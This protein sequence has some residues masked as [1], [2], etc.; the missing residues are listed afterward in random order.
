MTIGN[1]K[2]NKKLPRVIHDEIAD[3]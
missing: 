3:T 2:K 1:M